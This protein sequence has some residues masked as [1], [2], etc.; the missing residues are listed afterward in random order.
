MKMNDKELNLSESGFSGLK[1]FQDKN[2][3]ESGFSGLKEI[4]LNQDFQ[5]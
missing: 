1:D 2:L 3:S 4:C 5:D